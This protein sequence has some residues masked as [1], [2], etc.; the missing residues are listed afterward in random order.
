MDRLSSWVALG[1]LS[2]V[3]IG[4]IVDQDERDGKQ[5]Y[6][7]AAAIISL[8]FSCFITASNVHSSLRDVVIGSIP[9]NSLASLT[10]ALWVVAV[11]FI[12]SPQ[13]G[14][15]TVIRDGQE[16]IVY[17]NLYFFSW[18]AFLTSV[19]LVGTTFRDN[20]HFGPKFSQWTLL[21]A[22]SLVLLFT[23]IA[24]KE[25]IC[26]ATVEVTCD[27]IKYGVGVG[28]VGIAV[29]ILAVIAS[30]CGFMSRIVEIL[31]T[32][33]AAVMYFFG[34]VFLTSNNGPAS[35]MGNMYFSVWGGAAVSFALVMGNFLPSKDE[36]DKDFDANS[37]V[38]NG[39]VGNVA[40]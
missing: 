18:F 15:A 16:T 24:S 32:L 6:A 14:F 25:D 7:L 2:I 30:A 21:C 12:Q 9:E 27:R 36:K 26:S 19:Y 37:H 28:A 8:I 20:F 10:L 22:A 13:N 4:A 3:N 5:N 1:G 29:S 33:T 11:T 38:Q 34:V 23:S 17:A 40:L 39:D 35:S 31:I